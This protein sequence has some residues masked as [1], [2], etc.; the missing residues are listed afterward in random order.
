MNWIWIVVICGTVI[1]LSLFMA[2][3]YGEPMLIKQIK[4]LWRAGTKGVEGKCGLK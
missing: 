3:Q 2:L 4:N 1:F